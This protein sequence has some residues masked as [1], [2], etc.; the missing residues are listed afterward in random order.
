VLA[1]A[2]R[3]GRT[4]TLD[5]YGEGPCRKDL[6]RQ[7]RELGLTDQVRLRGY[8]ADV[9]DFLPGYRAYVHASY[10]ESS[11]LAIMEAMAAGLPVVA[12]AI[13]PL[14]ELCDEGVEGRFW[15]LDD[16]ARA[17]SILLGGPRRPRRPRP[18]SA[19]TST[20]A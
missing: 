14:A 18:V 13:G 4:L 9:R 20:P 5:A 11:S 10:S 6:E 3:A 17:A 1:E 7:A 2:R 8:R 15:P 19:G 16:P 12:G